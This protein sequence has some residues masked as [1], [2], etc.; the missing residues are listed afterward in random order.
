M[1]FNFQKSGNEVYCTN[2]LLL[3]IKM[4]LFSKLHCQ[5]VFKLK[6][7]SYKIR[8]GCARCSCKATPSL[9]LRAPPPQRLRGASPPELTSEAQQLPWNV[10]GVTTSPP[11]PST[12]LTSKDWNDYPLVQI[13][14]ID[15]HR[16]PLGV[17]V[18]ANLNS[19]MG[20]F[21][22]IV[23]VGGRAPRLQTLDGQIHG[24]TR[25]GA[26]LLAEL[27]VLAIPPHEDIRVR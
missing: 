25:G 3:L 7:I 9:R 10:R 14:R 23:R 20:R 2:A 24:Q 21:G 26:C 11:D 4:M 18:K 1:C 15:G 17:S 22:L 16:P 27:P 13:S 5:K 8:W 12:R 19:E 6:H